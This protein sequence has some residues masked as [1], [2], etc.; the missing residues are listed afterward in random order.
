MLLI[1]QP[2]WTGQ[3]S[4]AINPDYA[5]AIDVKYHLFC[6]VKNVQRSVKACSD[7]VLDETNI[8]M[9]A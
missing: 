2:E 5:R 9:V 6:W 1:K 7:H 8:G 3:V 4:T